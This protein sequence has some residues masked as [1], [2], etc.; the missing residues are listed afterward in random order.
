MRKVLETIL[1]LFGLDKP[2]STW[3]LDLL[4][5]HMTL[6]ALITLVVLLL[7]VAVPIIVTRPIADRFDRRAKARERQER[8]QDVTLAVYH[9]IFFSMKAALGSFAGDKATLDDIVRKMSAD[10]SYFPHWTFD[11]SEPFVYDN[12][13]KKDI[14]IFPS[15][16]IGTTVEFYGLAQFYLAYLKDTRAEMVLNLP[17]HRKINFIKTL[18][19]SAFEYIETCSTVLIAYEQWIST[20]KAGA[21]SDLDWLMEKKLTDESGVIG[22]DGVIQFADRRKTYQRLAEKFK[23]LAKEA[24]D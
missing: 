5:R 1:E 9:E 24:A 3:L 13:V 10:T 8:V 21:L 7:T 12:Y 18:F 4:A 17:P 15:E 14:A 6:Y 22:E 20:S 16:L 2:E 19:S 11:D 23:K